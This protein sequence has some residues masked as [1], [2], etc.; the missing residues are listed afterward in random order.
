MK[1][2]YWFRFITSLIVLTII[3]AGL[4]IYENNAIATIGANSATI[5][6]PSYAIGTEYNGT[7]TKQFV[8]TGDTVKVG[9][10]LFEFKSDQ[11]AAEITSGALNQNNL[12]VTPAQDGGYYIDA[13]KNGVINQINDSNGS[14]ISSGST[15][16]T[17]TSMNGASVK[18]NFELS[19][20]EYAKVQATTPVKI[21]LGGSIYTGSISGI[22]QQ[23][24]NGHT[25]TVITSTMPSIASSQTIY[26]SGTPV[27]VKIIVANHTYYQRLAGLI[28]KIK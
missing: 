16:A 22:T 28:H 6:F 15:I 14:F 21:S 3:C 11:L 9:Q 13:P 12:T 10:K 17:L 5:I 8:N 19:T 25:F 7:L 18:A 23:S 26:E 20:A 24:V 1:I 2:R 27:I 4:V